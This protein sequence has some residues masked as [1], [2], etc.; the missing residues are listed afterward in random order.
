MP[1]TLPE[2]LK[3]LEREIWTYYRELPRLLEEEHEGRIA[4]IRDD[5]VLSVWDT[6]GD[7][8]QAG[9]EKFGFERFMTQRIRSTDRQALEPYFVESPTRV[10]A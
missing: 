5:D 9:H 10:V 7:A 3:P 6:L 8:M 4:L 2:S 1:N